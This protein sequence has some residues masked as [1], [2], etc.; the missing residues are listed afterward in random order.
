MSNE[1]KMNQQ[2]ELNFY[3]TSERNKAFNDLRDN[4]MKPVMRSFTSI[5]TT[6]EGMNF[7]KAH[8][9]NFQVDLR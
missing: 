5:I 8:G 6:H 2:C 1:E 3:T 4:S 7:L 9:H